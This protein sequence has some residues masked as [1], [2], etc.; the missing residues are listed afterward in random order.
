[1]LLTKAKALKKGATVVLT[2]T[3]KKMQVDVANYDPRAQTVTVRT[4]CG[5][6]HLHTELSNREEDREKARLRYLQTRDIRVLDAQAGRFHHAETVRALLGVMPTTFDPT[7]EHEELFEACKRYVAA[8]KD[9]NL[10][11]GKTVDG[12]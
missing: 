8:H 12:K 4:T 3:G 10:L 1:M 11:L 2:R 7:T 9:V 6:T 5:S